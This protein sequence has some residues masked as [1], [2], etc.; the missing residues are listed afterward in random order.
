M[1][2][3]IVPPGWMPTAKMDRVILH[4]TAGRHQASGLDR[5]HYHIIVEGDGKLVRGMVPISANSAGA[6]PGT[7]RAAHTLN[8]NTGSIG[9]SL[10]CMGGRDVRE[11]PFVAGPW[12][13]TSVQ[14]NTGVRV[15]ADLIRAYGLPVTMETV[16]THAEVPGSLGIRQRG[17]WD[18]TVRAFDTS[19][20]GARAIGTILRAEV[21]ALLRVA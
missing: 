14:W 15:I 3:L 20:T 5:A 8:C 2:T 21:S 9:V 10:A 13:M 19:V 18:I 17:K 7:K 16:L 1:G 6:A 11:Y 12:P 4:W